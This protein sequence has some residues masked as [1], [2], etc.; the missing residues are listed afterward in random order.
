MVTEPAGD[1]TVVHDWFVGFVLKIRVPPGTKLV[2]GPLVDG[3]E[4]LLGGTDFN[5]GV[6]AI[7]C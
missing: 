2:A 6:D 3:V 4:F 5:T 1:D 7:G